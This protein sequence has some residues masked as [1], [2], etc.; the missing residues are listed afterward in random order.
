MVALFALMPIFHFVAGASLFF[1]PGLFGP[2]AGRLFTALGGG[3]LMVF[4]GIWMCIGWSLAALLAVA[5][6]YLARQQ[7]HTFCLVLACVEAITCVPFGTLLG[8]F[9]IVVLLRPSVRTAFGAGGSL[10]RKGDPLVSVA[11][12]QGEATERLP[13]DPTA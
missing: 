9:T 2:G 1:G 10:D 4:A 13:V 8:I 11:G 6:I 7:H 5:G 3:F 12:S